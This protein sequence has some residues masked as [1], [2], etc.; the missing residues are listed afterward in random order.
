ML[1][2]RTLNVMDMRFCEDAASNCNP[3]D[4]AKRFSFKDSLRIA[5]RLMYNDAWN[6]DLHDY[7]VDLFYAIREHHSEE[8]NSSWEYDALLGLACDITSHKHDERFLAYKAAYDKTANPPPSLLISLA[9]CV[10]CPGKKPLSY[11]QAISLL[12]QAIRLVPYNDGVCLLSDLYAY[13]GDSLQKEKYAAIARKQDPVI[14]SPSIEP[15]FLE[16]E[17]LQEVKKTRS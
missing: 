6:Y 15:S 10:I 12:L 11:D 5:Y 3:E 4:I 7:A 17:Y 1:F 9:S 13:K 2:K 16:E 8:W 14:D